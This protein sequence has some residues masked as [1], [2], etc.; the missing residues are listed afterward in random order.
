MIVTNDDM[1]YPI[2][3]IVGG[4]NAAKFWGIRKELFYK[5]MV[6]GFPRKYKFKAV[7]LE[8]MLYCQTEERKN[9]RK[10]YTGKLWRMKHDMSEINHRNYLK[11]KQREREEVELRC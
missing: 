5:Y 9:E 6:I 8:D 7:I 10:R 11:R 1:E 3:E 2:K 4:D